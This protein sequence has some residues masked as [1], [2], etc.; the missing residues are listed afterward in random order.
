MAFPE[1]RMRLLVDKETDKVVFAEAGKEEIDFLFSI[2][3][4]PLG[5]VTRLLSEE[6]GM[7]GCLGNIY[8]SIQNLDQSYLQPDQDKDCLLNPTFVPLVPLLLPLD[9]HETSHPTPTAKQLY[10]CS[11]HTYAA[12]TSQAH[13]PACKCRLS[14]PLTYVQWDV[15]SSSVMSAAGSDG[16]GGGGGGFVKGVVTYMVMDDLMVSPMS[17]IS[18]IVLLNKFNIKDVSSLEERLVHLGVD[19]GLKIL[20]ASMECKKV[21][22][23]VFVKGMM[24]DPPAA[25]PSAPTPAPAATVGNY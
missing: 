17:T 18:S 13:C 5:T 8:T 19:E 25:P 22:T 12:D 2:L 6:Q 7:V 16:G 24:R 23:T 10:K 20:K 15:T 11:N 14:V 9:H 3:S 4:L 21:L 1:L